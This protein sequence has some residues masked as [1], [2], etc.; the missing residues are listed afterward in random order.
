[1]IFL[2]RNIMAKKLAPFYYACKM[3]SDDGDVK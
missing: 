1:M 2:H 3:P